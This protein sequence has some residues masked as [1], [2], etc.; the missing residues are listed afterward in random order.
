MTKP[1]QAQRLLI[2][3]L[4]NACR[5]CPEKTA[6]E[7]DDTA[8]SYRQL[9]DESQ[10]LANLL[11]ARGLQ[12]GARVAVF[13]DNSW[14]CVVAIHAVMLA[15]GVLVL[16]NPQTKADKLE[17][18]LNDSAASMLLCEARLRTI[19]LAATRQTPALGHLLVFGHDADG[20]NGPVPCGDFLERPP[21]QELLRG[22]E[23]VIPTDLAAII[24]T[25]GSTGF[26]KGVMQTHQSMHFACWSLIEYLRLTDRERILLVLPLAFDYGLYQLFMSVNL[27]ACILVERSFAFPAKLYQRI[28]QARVSVFPGVPTLFAMMIAAYKAEQLT[29]PGVRTV[30]N[31]AAALSAEHIPWL[32]KVFPNALIF[33][34]YGLTECKRVCYLQ[35]ELLDRHPAS[36]GKAIPGTEV[37][38]LD[39][40]GAPVPPGGTGILHVR[41]PHLMVGYWR[42]PELSDQMLKPGPL[43]NQK[44]LCTQDLF[45]M[46]EQGLLYF[47]GRSDDIIKSRGEKVS[48][49]EIE[50]TLLKLPEVAEAAV[51][52]IADEVAG[53]AIVAFIS[54]SDASA[55]LKRIKMYCA[56]NLESFMVPR[57]IVVMPSLPRSANGKI[58]K[59]N[60]ASNYRPPAT[61]GASA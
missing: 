44:V 17:Y 33:K 53:Q 20:D 36:V 19:Y 29:F 13:M 11:L 27:A 50:N 58:D 47:V 4:I 43:P 6:V 37:Y 31:T 1:P 60:L 25:S 41:G 34:M 32:H 15:G 22:D 7:V 49:L 3:G 48:P 14:P 2:E 39:E 21:Q 45:R 35:P 10:R 26:P 5:L 59:K 56:R 52:G 40:Q 55:N 23:R 57:D 24:Y 54:G 16:V 61:A 28:E 18:I 51:V 38:L 9:H 8:Y 42:Q 30:T 12:R 46:D